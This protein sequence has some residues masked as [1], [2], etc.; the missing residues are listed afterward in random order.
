[1]GGSSLI[2]DSN[3]TLSCA[4]LSLSLLTGLGLNCLFGFWWADTIAGII[5]S[6]FLA[7]EGIETLRGDAD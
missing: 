6:V 5:I 3:E 7:R 1:L 4:F 2:A